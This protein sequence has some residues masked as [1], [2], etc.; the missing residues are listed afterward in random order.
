MMISFYFSFP[1]CAI[2]ICIFISC[3]VRVDLFVSEEEKLDFSAK[4]KLLIKI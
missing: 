2:V 3:V 4:E 1:N